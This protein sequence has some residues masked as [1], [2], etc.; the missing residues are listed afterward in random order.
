MT[1]LA[2]AIGMA[3][4]AWLALFQLLLAA[5]VPLGRLAWRGRHRVLPPR[6]RWA[7]LAVALL[8]VPCAIALGQAG[9]L[10]PQILAP[11]A[12]PWILWGVA[13][14]FAFS[15]LGNLATESRP[16]RLHGVPLTAVI[17]ASSLWLALFG[18]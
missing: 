13:A 10:L 8:A 2:G 17:V 12:L 1:V 3:A 6:L 11:A 14:L 4:L 16:E 5:G 15:L 18:A 7:S 9:G